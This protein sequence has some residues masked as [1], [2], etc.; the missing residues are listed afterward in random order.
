MKK[1]LTK[2]ERFFVYITASAVIFT[3]SYNTVIE[4]LVD[5]DRDLNIEISSKE[6]KLKKYKELLGQG[7]QLQKIY[8]KYL[9][10]E[11]NPA[12]IQDTFLGALRELEKLA[13][14]SGVVILDIRPDQR[15]KGKGELSESTI[16]LKSEGTLKNYLTFI[17]KIENT[18]S[19]LK[20]NKLQLGSKTNSELLEGR[21]TIGQ[22]LISD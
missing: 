22:I 13:G 21:F 12:D 10:S 2:R 18:P 5:K 15:R 11:G 8:K 7:D 20:I 14:A 16:E 6:I 4:P 19:L 3:I 9:F 17:Y 1:L